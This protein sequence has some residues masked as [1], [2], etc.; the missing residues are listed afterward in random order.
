MGPSGPLIVWLLKP[1]SKDIVAKKG[2]CQIYH[3]V[4]HSDSRFYRDRGEESSGKTLRSLDLDILILSICVSIRNKFRYVLEIH[5]KSNPVSNT[6]LSRDSKRILSPLGIP[7]AIK[8]YG[9][10]RREEIGDTEAG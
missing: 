7:Q 4:P 1:I 9:N 10:E 3:I 8:A 2:Q 5:I 6:N